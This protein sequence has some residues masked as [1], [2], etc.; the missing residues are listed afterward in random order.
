[1]L[2]EPCNPVRV[3]PVPELPVKVNVVPFELVIWSE[4]SLMLVMTPSVNVTSDTVV[5]AGTPVPVTVIPTA[6]VPD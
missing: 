6:M 3:T 5:P 1:M 4:L 2:T